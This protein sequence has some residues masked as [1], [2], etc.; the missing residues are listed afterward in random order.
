[1][2]SSDHG[3]PFKLNLASQSESNNLIIYITLAV[4]IGLII[5]WILVLLFAGT[6][7]MAVLSSMNDLA[8][9]IA[10]ASDKIG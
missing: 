4:V 9:Q 6:D 10:P 5:I 7:P 1:M 8:T 2:N 3:H